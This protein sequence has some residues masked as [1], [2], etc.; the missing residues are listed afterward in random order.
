MCIGLPMRVIECDG[1]SA[2]VERY[3]RRQTVNT[4]LLGRQ[5]PG[6]WLLVHIDTAVQRLDE[7]EARQ[8]DDALA[9][10][11]G[12]MRGE[13]IDHLFADLVDREPELPPHLR[14]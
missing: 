12:A 2:L 3:G 5:E 7:Q 11:D 13:D 1:V 14:K 6:Q 9:A 10:L 8:V 4:A